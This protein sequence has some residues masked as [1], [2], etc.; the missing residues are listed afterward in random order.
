M[1]IKEKA[2]RTANFIKSLKQA[3]GKW[4]GIS[5]DLMPW[6]AKIIRDIFGTVNKNGTRQYRTEYI[7]IPRKNG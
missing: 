2:D 1:Y 6:Q 5:F 4:L 3:T 7:E